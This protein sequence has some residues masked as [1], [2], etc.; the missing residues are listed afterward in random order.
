MHACGLVLCPG[1]AIME[2][3]VGRAFPARAGVAR[4]TY[5]HVTVRN[6]P[7]YC[8]YYVLYVCPMDCGVGL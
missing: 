1:G 3:G 5:I 4:R 6:L 2:N 8:R 7:D